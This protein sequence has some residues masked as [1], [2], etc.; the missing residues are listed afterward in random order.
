M[1]KQL[2]MAKQNYFEN[3]NKSGR[4]LAYK[5][6]KQKQI[7]FFMSLRNGKGEEEMSLGSMKKNS[8]RFLSSIT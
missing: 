4:W 8:R 1:E 3:A 6:K 2:K 5:L 7:N